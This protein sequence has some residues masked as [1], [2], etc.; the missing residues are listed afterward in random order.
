VCVCMCGGVCK[1]RI[2]LYWVATSA[3]GLIDIVWRRTAWRRCIRCLKMQVS[4]LKSATIYRA[5]LRKMSYT[6][7]ASHPFSPS[8]TN[9]AAN[10]RMCVHMCNPIRI[11]P[12][13]IKESTDGGDRTWNN[14]DC[15]NFQ[16]VFT[17]V[18]VHVKHVFTGFPE[19]SNKVSFE[20][21][22]SP[23]FK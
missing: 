15:Q 10:L 6:E 13:N 5:L 19:I 17:G 21:T 20:Y 3:F 2:H 1:I 22:E 4:F 11:A 9:S 18:P 7:K 12:Y 16:Q 14:Y 8:C 23:S